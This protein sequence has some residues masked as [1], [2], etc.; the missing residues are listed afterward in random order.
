MRSLLFLLACIALVDSKKK[1][2]A[3][4]DVN[5]VYI[6]GYDPSKE[7]RAV[8]R[9]PRETQLHPNAADSK[10]LLLTEASFAEATSG[11]LALVFFFSK[12]SGP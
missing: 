3:D 5:T 10:I 11:P 6:G 12:G 7:P 8:E 9:D 2:Q 4:E 1:K